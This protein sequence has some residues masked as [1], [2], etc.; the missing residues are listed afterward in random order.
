MILNRSRQVVRFD[1]RGDIWF[2]LTGH[3]RITQRTWEGD[4][5]RVIER[6]YTP[7]PLS[8]EER[9]SI[10]QEIDRWPANYPPTYTRKEIPETKPAWDRMYIGDEGNLI[11]QPRATLEDEGRLFDVFDVEGRFLGRVRSPVRFV[12]MPALPLFT[13]DRIYGV[14]TDSIGAEQVVRMRIVK[15][16]ATK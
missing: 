5:V 11:V 2:G 1:P 6:A 10:A 14:T 3:Y 4:T 7:A 16:R 15:D 12:T 8:G 13:G 9:D